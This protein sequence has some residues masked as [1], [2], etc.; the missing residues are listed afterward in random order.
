MCLEVQVH[1]GC[2]LG[3]EEGPLLLTQGVEI[4]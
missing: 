4:S 1:P 2:W 3:P